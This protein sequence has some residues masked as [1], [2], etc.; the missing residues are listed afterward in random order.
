MSG[1]HLIDH[2]E[3]FVVT[4]RVG[5][6]ASFS[7]H[8]VGVG[9]HH[10]KRLVEEL[11]G[12]V[13]L[14]HRNIVVGERLGDGRPARAPGIGTQ[15]ALHRLVDFSAQRRA[16]G[17]VIVDLAEARIGVEQV[18]EGAA[19]HAAAGR[20]LEPDERRLAPDRHHAQPLVNRL[21]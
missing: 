1:Q 11:D 5:Q 17:K 18:L 7:Q 21:L 13:E 10:R 4:A 14:L 6:R 19:V 20:R 9:R 16:E 15:Q 8:R 3:G 2:G 12:A